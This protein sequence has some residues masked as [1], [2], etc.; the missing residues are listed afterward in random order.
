VAGFA[1]EEVRA[2]VSRDDRK[3]EFGK[4]PQRSHIPGID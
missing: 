1:L 3:P 4:E 2:I